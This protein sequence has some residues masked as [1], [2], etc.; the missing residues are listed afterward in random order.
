VTGDA[1][2]NADFEEVFGSTR[3]E[4]CCSRRSCS[5]WCLLG[6]IYRSPVIAITPLIVV[7]AAYSVA[8]G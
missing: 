8:Q 6:A 4:T 5:C 1:G 7:F 2:F 3:H